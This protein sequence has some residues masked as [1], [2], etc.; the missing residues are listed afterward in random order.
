[1]RA[2]SRVEQRRADIAVAPR[3]Q[4]PRARGPEDEGTGGGRRQPEGDLPTAGL[5]AEDKS[6]PGRGRAL[7]PSEAIGPRRTGADLDRLL[8]ELERI[9]THAPSGR[10]RTGP[11]DG[12]APEVEEAARAAARKAIVASS[13]MT[14]PNRR[15]RLR[16]PPLSPTS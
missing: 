5:A 13:A 2:D 11:G 3:Q 6:S 12:L 16:R 15:P 9:G 1:M 4:A 14:R 8:G 7:R 10:S